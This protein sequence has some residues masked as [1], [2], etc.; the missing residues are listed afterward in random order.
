MPVVQVHCRPKSQDQL[1]RALKLIASAAA[2]GLDVDESLVQVFITEYDDDHWV[3]G[4]AKE[5]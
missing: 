3:K 4:R 5:A 2:E 1:Q